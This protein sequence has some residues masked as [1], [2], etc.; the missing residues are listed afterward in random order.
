[1]IVTL[2]LVT[3]ALGIGLY[4]LKHRRVPNV[5]LVLVLVPAVLALAIDGR[6]LTGIAPL[7]SAAGFGLALL[8]FLPGYALGGLGAGDVKFAAVIGLLLGWVRTADMAL[9]AC[10]GLGLLSLFWYRVYAGNR[11]ARFPASAAFAVAFCAELAGG[12]F[13][14]VLEKWQ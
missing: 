13:L 1:M 6:G 14:S 2:L 5:A 10:V 8:L 7:S 9:F 11:K 4:D 12:P 3:W